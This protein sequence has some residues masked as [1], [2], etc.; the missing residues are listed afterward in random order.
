MR[1]RG[2]GQDQG[3]ARA[4]INIPE[5]LRSEQLRGNI[6][7]PEHD[8]GCEIPPDNTGT[9]IV[10]AAI[11]GEGRHSLVRAWAEGGRIDHDVLQAY[12]NLVVR[13]WSSA[14]LEYLDGTR[15]DLRDGETLGLEVAFP[16]AAGRGYGVGTRAD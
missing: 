2:R 4:W 6:H 14:P 3:R 15:C 1:A 11:D 8:P 5:R 7:T 12:V 16:V 10:R 9:V 13:V